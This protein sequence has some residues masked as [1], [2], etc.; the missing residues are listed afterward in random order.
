MI[1]LDEYT[2]GIAK[3]LEVLDKFPGASLLYVGGNWNGYSLEAKEYCLGN[4]VGLYNTNDMAGA[5]HKDDF[6][7]YHRK[8]EKGNPIYAGCSAWRG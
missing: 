3:V 5:L 6:W 7:N 8:D 2:C 4:K 1:C